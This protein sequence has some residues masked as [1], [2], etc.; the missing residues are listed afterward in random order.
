MEILE[1]KSTKFDIKNSLG[2]PNSYLEMAEGLANLET[3]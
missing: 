1:L 3:D 2:S